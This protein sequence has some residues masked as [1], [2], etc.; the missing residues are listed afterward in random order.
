MQGLCSVCTV[1]QFM[2]VAL[3]I[4]FSDLKQPQFIIISYQPMG[5][6]DSSGDREWTWL[7]SSGIAQP[8]A[9]PDK[10]GPPLE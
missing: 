4:Q 9:A 8:S 2:V 1:Y 3:Q 10:L 6:L 5:C 7:I